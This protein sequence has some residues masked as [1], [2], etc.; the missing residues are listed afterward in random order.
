MSAVCRDCLQPSEAHD[1]RC[2]SCGSPRLVANAELDSL[3]IAHI[4][5]DAFYASV[6]KRDDPSLKDR[7][8]IVGGGRRGVVAACCYVARL[9]GVRSAMPMFK[10][11]EACP[12]AVVI[13]PNMGKYA[14]VG[15]EIREM[16]RSKTP[17]I[18]PLSIDE[19]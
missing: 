7:P 12:N 2:L 13:P 18:E 9:Y 5:C 10:A 16:M 17:L 8:V 6:E 14:R 15:A 3:A 4:D 19:A 11:L 1:Y